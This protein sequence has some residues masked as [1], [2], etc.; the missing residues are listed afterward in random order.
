MVNEWCASGE[1]PHIPLKGVCV[2][3]AHHSKRFTTTSEGR[4]RLSD[5]L[6]FFTGLSALRA[7][8]PQL[9]GHRRATIGRVLGTAARRVLTPQ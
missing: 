2:S 3:A 7:V 6:E 5:S 8:T 1:T 9:D 4:A